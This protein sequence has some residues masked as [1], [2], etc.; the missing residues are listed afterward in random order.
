MFILLAISAIC[1]LFSFHV[2]LPT[3]EAGEFILYA[4][5]TLF[6]LLALLEDYTKSYQK[7]KRFYSLLIC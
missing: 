6:L 1:N 5:H 3:S 4:L 2:P 7:S